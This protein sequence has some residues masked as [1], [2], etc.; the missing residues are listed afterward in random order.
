VK[1]VSTNPSNGYSA[2]GEVDIST[3]ADVA[4]AVAAARSAFSSWAGLPVNSRCEALRSFVEISKS[5]A[6]EIARIIVLE[7]GRPT[8]VVNGHVDYAFEYFE[9]Y[10]DQAEQALAPIETVVKADQRHVV[11][12]EPY[13]VIAAICPWNYPLLNVAWQCGQALLAGNTVVYKNSEENPLF[14]ELLESIVAQSSIPDGV[15]NVLYGGDNV[16][17]AMIDADIDLVSFT[18]STA[19][20]RRIAQ[21]AAAK[22]VPFFAE[23]SGS[24]PG[25]VFED[26]EIDEYIEEIF[27]R[28]FFYSGQ[29]CDSL[30]RLIVHETKFEEIVDKLRARAEK[31]RVGNAS[32]IDTELGPLVAERQVLQIEAQVNDSVSAGASI[33]TGGARP[34]GLAGAY[35]LPTVLAGVNPSM[36]VWAEETFGPVLPVVSFRTEDEAIR[37]AND[38]PYGLTAYVMTNDND[39]FARVAGAIRAGAVVQNHGTYDDPKSPFGGFKKSGF[40]RTNGEFGFHEVTQ[41]KLVSY[42]L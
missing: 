14:A 33:V 20:G 30:K 24:S 13:G 41:P 15:F 32:D 2:I 21:M 3:P 29:T 26:I 39:R 23:M 11:Q 37:L 35:Y 7:T 10:C 18:G 28:R 8:A 1:L 16:G 12:R 38:T 9:A 5:R 6:G 40:G 19:T 4:D 25:V 42:A 34:Q 22:Q 17:Q 27:W 36:R 31:T